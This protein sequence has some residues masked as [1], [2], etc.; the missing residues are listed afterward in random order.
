M[1]GKTAGVKGTVSNSTL[2]NIYVLNLVFLVQNKQDEPHSGIYR[3]R[4]SLG[5]PQMLA[6]AAPNLCKDC[7]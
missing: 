3:P 4:K 6:L 7:D 5:I 1:H 2:A